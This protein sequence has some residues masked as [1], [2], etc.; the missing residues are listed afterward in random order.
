MSDFLQRLLQ[1]SVTGP[2]SAESVL[3]SVAGGYSAADEPREAPPPPL[4][5]L[6]GDAWRGPL[7]LGLV[8][9]ALASL[10]V[11]LARQPGQ[12]AHVWFAN[13]VA[14]A[15]L[16]HRPYPRWPAPLVAVA[17]AIVAVNLAW[18]DSLAVAAGFVVP[19]LVE[20][21]CAAALLRHA[22]LHGRSI[23]AVHPLLLLLLLGAVLPQL[24]GALFGAAL[25]AGRGVGDFWRVWQVWAEGSV[26][27]AVSMLPLAHKAMR[28]GGGWLWHT[29]GHWQGLLLMV[30]AVVSTAGVLAYVPFPFIYLAMPLMLAA[31]RFDFALVAAL[32]LVVSVTVAV[33]LATGWFRPPAE[34]LP[35]RQ[36]FIYLAWT[37]ALVPALLLAAAIAELR[38]SH[39]VLARRSEELRQANEGM[40]QFVRILSHDMREPVNTITQFSGLIAED[41]AQQLPET[42]RTYL[43]LVRRASDRMRAL[44]D[45]LLQYTRLKRGLEG[46]T[47]RIELEDVVQDALH[48][49]AGQLRETRAQVRVMDLPAVRGH[50]APL[51]LMVQNLIGNAAKFMPPGREPQI[52]VSALVEG[53]WVDLRVSDNGIGIDAADAAKLFHPFVR[54][55][56]RRHYEGTGL[57][58]ALVRQVAEAHGGAVSIDSVPGEGSTFAV[59]L[60]AALAR[61]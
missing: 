4:Y 53:P 9:A 28:R 38:A 6:V 39:A 8:Y 19:N 5:P 48:V 43:S 36:S 14:V 35:A 58:L 56:L 55:N 50:E 47:E 40:E 15:V 24:V 51:V 57:G 21:M 22:G 60:P 3:P 7:M 26:L 17:V 61:R 45:D 49:L 42:S 30:A 54:L 33:S 18:G 59:R 27:G 44:L 11:L 29:A 16:M 13:A 20:V 12:I 23:A 25:L 31:V 52:V 1:S 41:N 46:A 2:G 32:T 37:A 10:S 34:L